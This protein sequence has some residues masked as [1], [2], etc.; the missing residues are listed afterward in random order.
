M[1]S[2]RPELSE[3]TLKICAFVALLFHFGQKEKEI[4]KKRKKQK[5]IDKK[6]YGL[7][8]ERQKE[9]KTYACNGWIDEREYG[10]TSMPKSV[11][12]CYLDKVS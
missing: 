2:I 5:N 11:R 6:K 1:F 3:F 10:T 9:R 7:C 8:K 12:R 4:N